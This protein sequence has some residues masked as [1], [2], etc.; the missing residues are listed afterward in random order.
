MGGGTD[1]HQRREGAKSEL[2]VT[3]TGKL[4]AVHTKTLIHMEVEDRV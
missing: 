1:T 3:S 4:L 2:R